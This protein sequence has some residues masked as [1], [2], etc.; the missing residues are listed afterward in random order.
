MNNL[1]STYLRKTYNF[2]RA[3]SNAMIVQFIFEER[4]LVIEQNPFLSHQFENIQFIFG[5]FASNLLIERALIVG[6]ETPII[7]F[8]FVQFEF[9]RT[10][11]FP[12]LRTCHL[13]LLFAVFDIFQRIESIEFNFSTICVRQREHIFVENHFG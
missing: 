12:C 13:Q 10:T 7:R 2:H 5:V 11:F 3:R 1:F 8:D 9:I 6:G 4:Q